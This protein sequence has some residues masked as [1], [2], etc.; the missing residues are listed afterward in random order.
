MAPHSI[1]QPFD[2][3]GTWDGGVPT[4]SDP[5]SGG[6]LGTLLIV[7]VCAAP[8]GPYVIGNV[9][10]EQLVIYP[11]AAFLALRGRTWASTNGPWRLTYFLLSLF[12][13][14]ACL[15]ALSDAGLPPGFAPLG[16]AAGVDNCAIALAVGLVVVEGYR[17]IGLDRTLRAAGLT[18]AIGLGA[19]AI[20]ELLQLLGLASF[21]SFWTSNASDIVTSAVALSAQTN[22]RYSGIF[23]Q[24]GEAGAAYGLALIVLTFLP[25]F[26]RI[27]RASLLPLIA[28]GGLL[29][30]SKIF[31]L[32]VVLT[33]LALLFGS[34]KTI[35]VRVTGLAVACVAGSLAWLLAEPILSG[36]LS[37][38]SYSDSITGGLSAG[39]LG[40]NGTNL[41]VIDVVMSNSP[42]AGFGIAGLDGI[43]YDSQL[44]ELLIYGGVIGAAIWI[45]IW[46][47]LA[48]GALRLRKILRPFPVLLLLFSFGAALGF[49]PFTANRIAVW[50]WVFWFAVLLSPTPNEV[51]REN[52]GFLG[53]RASGFY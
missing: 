44:V 8:F 29:P 21:Q 1:I 32:A 10:L 38:L 2:K 23:N 41:K 26:R 30:G 25:V 31:V 16:V 36:F 18:L 5:S 37:R 33:L 49:S 35:A 43:A 47:T 52:S 28:L 50:M 20:A 27:E 40:D 13:F 46:L 17:R 53:H 14:V 39:R 15:V 9:R 42:L 22:G 45:L 6:R 3:K 7:I 4:A 24:P 12:L 51:G 34:S 11:L 48:Y 19:N